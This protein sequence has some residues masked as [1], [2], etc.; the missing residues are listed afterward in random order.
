MKKN[1]DSII[2]ECRKRGIPVECRPTFHRKLSYEVSG[3]SKSGIALVY[4]DKNKIICQTKYNNLDEVESFHDLAIVALE[5][6]LNYKDRL[7]FEE[8]EPYWAEYWVEKG[9]MQKITK[10]SYRLR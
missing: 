2:M 6:Y 10:I 4:I 8:P 7:P 5:W 3:F 9:I 1:L